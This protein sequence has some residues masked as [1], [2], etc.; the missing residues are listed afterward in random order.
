MNMKK[1]YETIKC[2]ECG[3][4]NVKQAK[5]CKKCKILLDSVLKT[6]PRCAKRNEIKANK[7]VKCG[8]DFNK[9]KKAIWINMLISLALV[10]ALII[11]VLLNKTFI[12]KEVNQAFR[13]LALV[14][15]AILVISTLTYG[16]K[17]IVP[18]P[19]DET[20]ILKNDIKLLKI[21]S[22]VLGVITIIIIG[23]CIYCY[24]LFYKK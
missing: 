4:E 1:K 2:P 6:C 11:L 8:Y 15:V 10:V 7:C 9:K 24:W 5:K 13:A 19:G 23:L 22:I 20:D 3:Y 16:K 14:V 12:V 18:L 17:D 21:K